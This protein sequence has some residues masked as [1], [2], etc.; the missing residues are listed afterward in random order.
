MTSKLTRM[1]QGGDAITGARRKSGG[2]LGE[3]FTT[4]M[5]KATVP[6]RGGGRGDQGVSSRK[7]QWVEGPGAIAPDDQPPG[8]KI[9]HRTTSMSNSTEQL[10]LVV[11]WRTEIR[12]L[13]SCGETRTL[14]RRKEDK[15]I[16]PKAVTGSNEPLPT[17]VE[18]DVRP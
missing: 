15:S 18:G 2:E 7:V 9:L 5:S 6:Q 17:T 1:T 11:N 14:L 13:I 16:E 3:S 12:F 10:L 4:G 8:Q